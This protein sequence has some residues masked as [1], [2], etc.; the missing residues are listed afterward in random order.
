MEKIHSQ[1]LI[2]GAGP[3]G[4]VAAIYG[5]IKGMKVTLVDKKRVGGTCLNVG[6]IP[7]KALVKAADIFA[8]T[9]KSAAYGI[10]FEN[11]S[12][13]M[14]QT[15]AKKDEITKTLTDGIAFL[16]NK[17]GV[18]YV[19]GTASFLN[20]TEVEVSG[21]FGSKVYTAD[22][23]IIATGSKTK[24]LPIPGLDNDFVVDSEGLLANEVLPESMTVIGGGI[25]G[26][27]FAFIYGQLG[28]K[29]EVLEFLPNILPNIDKDL[30]QR[31]LRFAKQNNIN[32]TTGARVTKIEKEAN[33]N[34]IVTYIH[35]DV[36]KTTTSNLVL[37]AVGR[38]PEFSGLN[39]EKTDIKIGK[40]R[41]IEVDETMKTNLDHIYA[42]GDATNIMQ[43]AHVASHQ[44][45]NAIDNILGHK[46]AMNYR[47]IPS[48][49]FT[50]PQIATVGFSEAE[51]QQEGIEYTT[52]RVP[53]SSNGKALILE[54]NYGFI[55]LLQKAVTKEII[56]AQV[57]GADAEHLIAP[58]TIA[59]KNNLSLEDIKETVF[60]HPTTSEMI[61]EG[62]LGLNGE[63]IH[64]LG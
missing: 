56:G 64:Y 35:K 52:H 49:I 54:S 4:Y 30:S 8:E 20:N 58:L 62:F 5:A 61:H 39:L 21:D 6:C 37:E 36:E 22:K 9:K 23:I 44:A 63:A 31:L 12:I 14:K 57:F 40:N 41:G 2:I 18:D 7:T 43:L 33:G 47:F 24:H 3:G 11:A 13:D 25:I 51:L 60:A 16:L 29:V 55:K 53:F 10:H 32:I 42:V 45:I 46:S 28:V 38:E 50:S 48:V 1:I 19:Q 34:A 15:I 59:L 27:E 17:H 26:M